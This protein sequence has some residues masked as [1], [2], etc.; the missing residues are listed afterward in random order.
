MGRPFQLFT[1]E[2]GDIDKI[3]EKKELRINETLNAKFKL[4]DLKKTINSLKNNKAVG[5]DKIANEFLKVADDNL[6]TIFLNLI[7][8]KLEKGSTCTDWCQ[9]II[10]LI[11]KEGT[12]QD[13]NNYRGIC[14]M[15]ALMKVL[16]ILLNNRLT[17][18]CEIN[19]LRN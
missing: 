10:S 17:D 3:M 6:L 4:D 15:T 5:T 7:N 1:K 19:K 8:L 16:C 12:K 2:E 9:G 14:I 18:F 11:H 13:P